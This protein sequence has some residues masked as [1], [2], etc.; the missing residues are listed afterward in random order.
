VITLA[1]TVV[2]LGTIGFL[3][4]DKS[5]Y[6]FLDS[7]YRA[8]LLFGFGGAVEPDVPATLEIARF[9]GPLVAGYAVVRGLLALFREQ[10]QLLWF[11]LFLRNHV[12]VAGLGAA[13]SRFARSFHVDGYRVVAVERAPDNP[14]IRACR[15]LG[16]PV[17][18]GDARHKAVLRKV[19]PARAA[20]FVA[21]CGTDG[22]N[23]DVATAASDVTADRDRG[24]LTALVQLDDFGL[25]G[26]LKAQALT[27]KSTSS[28]R[29]ALFNVFA[30]GAEM[31]SQQH[32][33]FP[34]GL[35]RRSP[36]V[37]LVGFD[38]VA[39]WLTLGIM[40]DWERTSRDPDATLT[41]TVAAPAATL[42]LSEFRRNYP[43]AVDPTGCRLEAWDVALDAIDRRDELQVPASAVYVLIEDEADA[44]TAA[45]GLSRRPDLHGVPIAVVITDEGS[46]VATALAEG[47][48]LLDGVVPFG[49]FTHVFTPEAFLY[50]TNEALAIASHETH[51]RSELA[52]GVTPEQDSSL[53][54]WEQLPE[55][56]RES[57]RLF[58]DSIPHKL[59]EVDCVVGLDHFADPESPPTTFD[60]TEIERLAPMEHD[61][62]S[63]DMQRHLGYR[64]T[65]GDKDTSRGL[66]PYVGVPF[67]EV[68]QENQDK[69]RE[70]I[71][72]IP[73]I[74][75]R[76]GFRIVR[77]ASQ[78]TPE[79]S[80][81]PEFAER[82]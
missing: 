71:R 68:P 64:W 12:I 16:I 48:P 1:V 65:S 77:H 23:I 18:I 36:H 73:E 53:V 43:V 49:L 35:G 27:R 7:L 33:P 50:T 63:E 37:L 67:D 42:A 19:Q 80:A 62:W 47:G 40:R 22:V 60:P 70:K 58:A 81:D 5:D 51:L 82:R 76:A 17:L 31:L 78:G 9:L 54:P 56:L 55:R 79:R 39:E 29:L 26:M 14:A 59:S 28:F 20:R 74:L 10:L 13:G 21:T 69:D 30:T 57:N 4:Y 34:E 75:A 52:K 6:E 61:R 32:P 38:G 25:L 44:L 66:H 24:V 45:L 3:E 15:E 46:G 72:S 8:F 41:I 11:R 2:T